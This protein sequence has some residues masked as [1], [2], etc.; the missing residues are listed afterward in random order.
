MTAIITPSVRARARQK[1]FAEFRAARERRDVRHSHFIR[2]EIEITRERRWTL[3]GRGRFPS[4]GDDL[5]PA[6]VN[7]ADAGVKRD[8]ALARGINDER[9]A[10]RPAIPWRRGGGEEHQ[11]QTRHDD[12]SYRGRVFELH[13]RGAR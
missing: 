10:P 6:R 12:G 2:I 11:K 3:K 1:G 4:R 9:E 13:L 5:S 7:S 8:A